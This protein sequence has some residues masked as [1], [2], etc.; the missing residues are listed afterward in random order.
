MIL[1]LQILEYLCITVPF[2]T[3]E[4]KCAGVGSGTNSEWVSGVWV[5]VYLDY[6]GNCRN[7][8]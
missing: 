6:P 8:K 3:S 1:L 2:S 5:N 4:R 7:P